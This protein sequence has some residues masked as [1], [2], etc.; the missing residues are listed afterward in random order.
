[1]GHQYVQGRLPPAVQHNEFSLAGAIYV[2]IAVL[3]EE[4]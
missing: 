1:M 3:R 2:I 4:R